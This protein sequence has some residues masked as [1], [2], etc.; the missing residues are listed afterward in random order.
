MIT[1]FIIKLIEKEEILEI[2]RW[3]HST[4]GAPRSKTNQESNWESRFLFSGD[5]SMRYV[6]IRFWL[7]ADAVAFKLKFAEQITE[8]KMEKE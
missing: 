3:L 7:D 6:A 2:E 4:L 8:T 5:W 1:K